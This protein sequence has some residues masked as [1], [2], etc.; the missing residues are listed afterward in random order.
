MSS[1]QVRC[2]R[3]RLVLWFHLEVPFAHDFLH[4]DF[5]TDGGDNTLNELLG[6][7]SPWNG[8][9][10]VGVSITRRLLEVRG[11]W[12]RRQVRC[13][14]ARPEYFSLEIKRERD[15]A[16]VLPKVVTI[17]R[18][19]MRDPSA[20]VLPYPPD[21]DVEQWHLGLLNRLSS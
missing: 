2:S 15:W 1:I 4:P 10:D 11:N 18:E 5:R 3:Y 20:K 21:P 9:T 6:Q 17:I 8:L 16:S 13:L 12:F 7:Q 19:E 14:S